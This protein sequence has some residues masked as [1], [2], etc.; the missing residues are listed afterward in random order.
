[1]KMNEDTFFTTTHCDRCREELSA[2]IMSWFNDDCIC[3]DCSSKEQKIRKTLPNSGSEYEGCGY[4]PT[5]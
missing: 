3:M 4:I 2:R 5:K 1:M